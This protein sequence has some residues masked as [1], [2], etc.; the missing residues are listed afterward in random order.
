[1]ACSGGHSGRY[2]LGDCGLLGTLGLRLPVGCVERERIPAVIRVTTGGRQ[3]E[4]NE[5]KNS[6]LNALSK[7]RMMLIRSGINHEIVNLLF[8]LNV[9]RMAGSN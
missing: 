2:L 1:M 4:Q 5:K 8:V 6:Q 7:A 9:M 3:D